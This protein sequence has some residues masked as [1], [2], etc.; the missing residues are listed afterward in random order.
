MS[1]EC[2]QGPKHTKISVPLGRS[3]W[4]E[5]EGNI[6]WV[7]HGDFEVLVI[8]VSFCK[9]KGLHCPRYECAKALWKGSVSKYL[10]FA[11]RTAPVAIIQLGPCEKGTTDYL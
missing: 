5:G 3:L 7:T 6:L 8:S 4:H 2:P 9:E 10:G 1:P 11:G